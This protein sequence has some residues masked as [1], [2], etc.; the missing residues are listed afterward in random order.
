MPNYD[1]KQVSAIE[2]A[3]K[4]KYGDFAVLDPSSL[5]NTEK[6]KAYLDQIKVFDKYYRQQAYE[7]QVDQG[8]FIIKEKLIN[9]KNFENCSLCGEQA[10]KTEDDLYMNKY[11]CCFKCFIKHIEG[12]EANVRNSK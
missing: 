11:N 8:G 3:V 10:Y 1:Y 12:R 2:K 6:E 7:N 5:W 9:K 4:E